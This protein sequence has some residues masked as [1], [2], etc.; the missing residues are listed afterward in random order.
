M[1]HAPHVHLVVVASLIACGRSGAT[2]QTSTG[3]A[4][5]VISL[6]PSVTDFIVALGAADRLAGR[7][8]YDRDARIAEV[9]SVGGTLDPSV[10]RILSL[11]P[12]LIISWEELES[13]PV[14]AQLDRLNLP[15]R[16][17]RVQTLADVRSVVTEL[18][19]WFD[20][21]ARAD[22]MLRALDDTLAAVRAAAGR[23]VSLTVFYLVQLDPP[24][25]AGAGTFVDDL[26]AVAGA[27]NVFSDVTGA[28]PVVALESII[29]RHPDLVLWARPPGGAPWRQALRGYPGWFQIAA[30]R[31]GRVLVVDPD[32]FDRPGPSLG[33]AAR[34]LNQVLDSVARQ[35]RGPGAS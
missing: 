19:R 29:E 35:P 16:R 23:R 1:S 34:R 5:R 20:L 33:R 32:L 10:E 27:R 31:E 30:V 17:V 3:P 22:S 25:T 15:V 18:G 14:R 9:P 6:V 4:H 13:S 12:D 11:R 28:W 24:V 21:Q 26:I 2:V 8:D 7:T